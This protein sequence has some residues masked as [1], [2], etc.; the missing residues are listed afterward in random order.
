MSAKRYFSYCSSVVEVSSAIFFL[1]A[2]SVLALPN[3]AFAACSWSFNWYCSGPGCTRVMGRSTGTIGGFSSESQCEDMRSQYRSNTARVGGG[4]TTGSCSR[5]GVCDE[6]QSRRNLPPTAPSGPPVTAP[7]PYMPPDS[8]YEVERQRQIEEDHLRRQA[9]AEAEEARRR[10]DEEARQEKIRQDRLEALRD[11]QG[12]DFDA[13]R[14][15]KTNSGNELPIMGS[16][17]TFEI[18]TTPVIEGQKEPFFTKGSRFSAPVDLRV[19]DPDGPLIVDPQRIGKIVPGNA[20]ADFVGAQAWPK[21]A[22]ASV[23][24][25]ILMLERGRYDEAITGLERARKRVAGDPFIKD[26]LAYSKAQRS[27][28]IAAERADFASR[29]AR[30][31]PEARAAYLSG[32]ARLEIGD[33]ETALRMFR[34]ARDQGN[35]L[36]LADKGHL[37]RVV[38]EV[39]AR[40]TPPTPEQEKTLASWR[41]K[42]ALRA[43]GEAAWKLGLALTE[44][45]RGEHDA[46]ALIY[47]HDAR[48]VL[49]GSDYHLIDEYANAVRAKSIN[50]EPLM[51]MFDSRANAILDALQYGKGNLD[52]SLRYLEDARR[53]E[54]GNLHIRDAHQYLSGLRAGFGAVTKN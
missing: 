43:R 40:Y 10:A 44:N 13:G 3:S 49:R 53:A 52:D 11:I 16:S 25:A 32:W 45:P 20:L 24:I 54:P 47:L 23:L 9:E 51:S 22:K 28:A 35:N 50:R 21:E 48:E 8:N 38:R 34:R 17:P 2:V 30:G 18:M 36:D 46:R 12:I 33:I 1:A 14:E 15:S 41:E 6:P 29:L 42:A 5:S 39:E 26:A 27:Q 19:R 37:D 4:I 31:S 7:P